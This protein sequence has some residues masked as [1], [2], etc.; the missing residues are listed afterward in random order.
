[1]AWDG[2]PRIH[3]AEDGHLSEGKLMDQWGRGSPDQL[4]VTRSSR[5]IQQVVSSGIGG[6]VDRLISFQSPGQQLVLGSR[7]R[8]DRV[9]DKEGQQV[10]EGRP[11]ET[12]WADPV[13]QVRMEDQQRKE[14][15]HHWISAPGLQQHGLQSGSQEH[16]NAATVSSL[17]EEE[18]RCWIRA[19][20]AEANT[21]SRKCAEP[22]EDIRRRPVILPVVPL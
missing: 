12:R 1:M 22:E 2:Q 17:R 7:P 20:K 6:D 14:D 21:G 15:C 4:S 16:Q 11:P 5:R 3:A 8:D 19:T 9:S 13:L 10:F 18:G